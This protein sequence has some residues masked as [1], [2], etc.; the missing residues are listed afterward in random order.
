M[1][2][3]TNQNGKFNIVSQKYKEEI[4]KETLAKGMIAGAL[5]VGAV[6]SMEVLKP[7]QASAMD[8]NIFSPHAK[9][10]IKNTLI[11]PTGVSTTTYDAS[12]QWINKTMEDLLVKAGLLDKH[13]TAIQQKAAIKNSIEQ[14]LFNMSYSQHN[15]YNVL[16]HKY[17]GLHEL[18]DYAKI[19]PPDDTNTSYEIVK[20]KGEEYVIWVFKTAA[21]ISK[22]YL[23][24]EKEFYHLNGQN[25]FTY[26][27][28]GN[29][30]HIFSQ[31]VTF[32]SK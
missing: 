12:L 10:T 4:S 6:G 23:Q 5:A 7:S 3:K 17:N 25:T 11:N 16:V 30:K 2:D 28:N 19:F 1:K 8:I 21:K 13:L 18:Q 9:G 22:S 14:M 26:S 24:G 31:T 20:I 32:N 29:E 15:Q 27:G